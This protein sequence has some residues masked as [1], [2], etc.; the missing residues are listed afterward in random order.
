M[1][2]IKFWLGNFKLTSVFS[3]EYESETLD[4]SKQLNMTNSIRSNQPYKYL[5]WSSDATTWHSYVQLGAIG[6]LPELKPVPE[7]EFELELALWE[8]RT[9][10]LT[11]AVM[12][13][14]GS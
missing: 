11:Q 9:Y 6:T 7:I 12:K 10:I 2:I 13:Q 8:A 3:I 5:N 1:R 14:E 4:Q